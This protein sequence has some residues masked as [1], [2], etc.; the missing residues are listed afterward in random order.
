M[1]GQR[2]AFGPVRYLRTTPASRKKVL[3]FIAL[4]TS[5]DAQT[6]EERCRHCLN[7]FQ[8]LLQSLQ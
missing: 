1:A 6:G 4:P 5:L 8:R 3:L 2:A 7:L